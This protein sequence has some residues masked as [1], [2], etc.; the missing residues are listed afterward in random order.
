MT[1][2]LFLPWYP[3]DIEWHN[4]TFQVTS[5]LAP[6]ILHLWEPW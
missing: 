1:L 5:W 4:V 2:E 3:G 6:Y